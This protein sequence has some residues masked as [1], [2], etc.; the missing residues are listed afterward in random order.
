VGYFTPWAELEDTTKNRH[1]ITQQGM[2]INVN[3]LFAFN[4]I[5]SSLLKINMLIYNTQVIYQFLDPCSPIRSRT[6]FAGMTG[7]DG[8]D[9]KN[10]SF[11]CKREA[12]IVNNF[13]RAFN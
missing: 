10:M 8:T 11:P 7:K 4:I 13:I 9:R 6:G 12:S 3:F 2:L 1:T 5:S